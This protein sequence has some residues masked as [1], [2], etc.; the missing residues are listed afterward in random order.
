MPDTS[1]LPAV[2]VRELTI[3]YRRYLSKHTSLKDAVLNLLRGPNTRPS[4]FSISSLSPSTEE[5]F[6]ESSVKTARQK[7][8]PSDCWHLPP[9]QG[10]I[11]AR[12]LLAPLLEL[13]GFRTE[14]TWSRE[15]WIN[16]AIMGLKRHEI[17]SRVES[18]VDFAELGDFID[19]PLS[20]YSSGMSEVWLRGS[21]RYKSGYSTH[22]R[23]LRGWR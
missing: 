13:G 12:G 7:H 21:H 5:K 1:S 8:T 19:S 11:I 15:H 2:E 22:R 20:T 14:L 10:S 3:Q 18:I 16:G 17:A 23:G 6:S 4:M 9:K